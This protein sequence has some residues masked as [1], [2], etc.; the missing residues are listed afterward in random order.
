[1]TAERPFVDFKLD[2]L[3]VGVHEVFIV[4]LVLQTVLQ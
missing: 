4:V 3:F 1:M 2:D